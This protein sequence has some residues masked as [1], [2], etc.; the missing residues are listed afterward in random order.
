MPLPS[1]TVT[2]LFTDIAGSTKL[3][4]EQPAM[5]PGVLARHDALLRKAIEHNNGFVV[6][7]IGDA[8]MAVFLTALDGVDAALMAQRALC[9]EPWPAEALVRVRMGL[10]TGVTEE[11]DNDYYGYE[12][13]RAARIQGVVH[14][15]QIVVSQSVVTQIEECLPENVTLLDLGPHQLK[16]LR[17]PESLWQLCHPDLP[18]TFPPLN[19]LS[20]WP[21]NLPRQVSSFIGREAQIAEV[22]Q[23]LARSACLTLLGSGGC[24]KTRMALQV[25]AEALPDYPH[26]IWL[27]ELASLTEPSLVAQ[28]V[29]AAMGIREEP[30][31]TP[32]QAVIEFCTVMAL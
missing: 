12:V 28:T 16:D 10:H 29:A 1:G 5:M 19:S 20:Y 18:A 21:N 6:K 17:E 11:R 23:L 4:Q 32:Q 14:P 27:S 9:A 22:R 7:T 13:N 26:G 30:G 25:A 8:F 3:W 2:F 24:G 15:E 31:K